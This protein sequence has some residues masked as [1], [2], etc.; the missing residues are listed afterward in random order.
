MC[1]SK[2]GISA[3]GCV[4]KVALKCSSRGGE[5]VEDVILYYIYIFCV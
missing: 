5:S 2:A 4:L 1:D 3:V